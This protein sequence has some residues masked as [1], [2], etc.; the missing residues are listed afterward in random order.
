[1]NPTTPSPLSSA[2]G[3]G[4]ATDPQTAISATITENPALQS[5][6]KIVKES[7]A[8]RGYEYINGSDFAGHVERYGFSMLSP[9]ALQILKDVTAPVGHRVVSVCTGLGYS[10][11][12]M[13]AAGIEVIGFDRRVP[14]ARWLLDTHDSSQGLPLARF[15]DRALFISFPDPTK[16]A[17]EGEPSFPVQVIKDFVKVGGSIVIV[18]T[19]ARP[20]QHAIRCDQELVDLLAKGGHRIAE[21]ALPKWPTVSTFTGYGHS[22]H[23]FEPVLKAYRL[24]AE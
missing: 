22:Y 24:G 20:T 5:L 6:E 12:Q 18:V 9:E 3:I 7:I 8:K 16:K 10:E 11:A 15:S 14:D 4:A 1:M 19:E 21:V 23:T 17:R 13:V 2:R